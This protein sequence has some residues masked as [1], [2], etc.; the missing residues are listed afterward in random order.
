MAGRPLTPK[1][2]R[3][4]EEYLVDLNATAAAA[5]AGYKEANKQ[6]PRLLVNVGVAAAVQKAKDARSNRTEIT[7]DRVLKEL[8]RIAFLDPRKVM[9]WGP[10]GVT[11][12]DSDGLT[13]DEARCVAEASET[14]TES[15]GSIK[16]KLLDKLRA[17]ELIGKHL[18]MW[19]E[20]HEHGGPGGGPVQVQVYIPNNGRDNPA[21][22][23]GAVTG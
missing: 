19:V 23:P 5:R 8:G 12:L 3:F 14:V 9:K 22:A 4:V 15:G 16:V 20:R 7:A 1:Q 13:D 2:Q 21:P 11:F 18:G 17:L 10:D 6:G